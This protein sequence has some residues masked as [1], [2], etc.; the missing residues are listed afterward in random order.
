M[1]L[2]AADGTL[3]AQTQTD[4]NGDYQFTDV[5]PGDYCVVFV[6]NSFRGVWTSY[7]ARIADDVNGDVDRPTVGCPSAG[8]IDN[9]FGPDAEAAHAPTFTIQPGQTYL[10]VDAGLIDLSG[11]GSVDISG[12]VWFDVNRDGI[13]Q[14]EEV[15]RVP[16]ILVRLAWV[17]GSQA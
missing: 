9:I 11:V 1:L 14:P 2:F 7:N 5:P 10:D 15:R 4:A 12:L 13:R 3:I 8:V 16:G 6:S 17:D